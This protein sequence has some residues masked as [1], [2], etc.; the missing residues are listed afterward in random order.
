MVSSVMVDASCAG[1]RVLWDLDEFLGTF[2]RLVPQEAWT[3]FD[4]RA[5]AG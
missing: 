5:M 4:N 1:D 2:V 3:E